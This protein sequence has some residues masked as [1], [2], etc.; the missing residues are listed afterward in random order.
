[1][2]AENPFDGHDPSLG[3][4][5]QC[6]NPVRKKYLRIREAVRVLNRSMREK[7][8]QIVRQRSAQLNK[9]AEELCWAVGEMVGKTAS[10]TWFRM[11]KEEYHQYRNH[12]A[13][14]GCADRLAEE[15]GISTNHKDPSVQKALTDYFKAKH[16]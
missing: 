5:C 14:M 7:R 4:H 16:P 2:S 6:L 13:L 10:F 3:S 9:M 12:K 1:M 15:L 8:Y 11:T